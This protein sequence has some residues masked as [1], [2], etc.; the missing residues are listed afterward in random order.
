MEQTSGGVERRTVLV[1]AAW[2]VPVIA[3]ALAA[4]AAAAST[5]ITVDFAAV[6]LELPRETEV[7]AIIAISCSGDAV[8]ADS[9]TIVLE[10][11]DE[12]VVPEFRN[13]DPGATYP[14]GGDSNSNVSVDNSGFV[15]L[16]G[17]PTGKIT[18][19]GTQVSISSAVRYIGIFLSW[20]AENPEIDGF[21]IAGSF[22]VKLPGQPAG[23]PLSGALPVEPN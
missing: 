6:Y 10:M 7:L 9:V 18:I 12:S 21:T 16:S 13:T 19:V 17:Q 22:T 1:G 23:P 5:T 3:V 20:P 14:I 11:I 8:V 4:P 2:S 15:A